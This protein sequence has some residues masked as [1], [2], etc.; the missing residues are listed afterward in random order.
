MKKGVIVGVIAAIVVVAGVGVALLVNNN[1]QTKDGGNN[2]PS[3]TKYTAIDACEVFTEAEAKTVL[4]AEATLGSNTAPATSDDIAV[5]N[6]NYTNNATSVPDVRTA[7]LLARSAMTDTGMESNQAAFSD[8][9]PQDAQIVEGY[10]EEAFYTPSTGQLSVL[11]D[12]TWYLIT[13]GSTNPSNYSLDKVKAMADVI[14][15]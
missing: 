11:K 6:C 15:K 4:G 2:T 3:S 13:Y 10:G 7:T 12:N 14:V 9:R 5:S 8:G 1:R